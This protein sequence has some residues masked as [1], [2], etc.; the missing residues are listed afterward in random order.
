[1]G[2]GISALNCSVLS[3]IFRQLF[4]FSK[5]TRLGAWHAAATTCFGLCFD[6]F[7][8]DALSFGLSPPAPKLKP[9]T[10]VLTEIPQLSKE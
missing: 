1:M 7:Q 8:P 10:E 6:M 4:P 9:L 5:G 2:H 3:L